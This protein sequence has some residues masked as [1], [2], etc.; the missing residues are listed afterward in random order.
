MKKSHIGQLV[1]I[2]VFI[3]LVFSLF[4][5]NFGSMLQ[6]SA[7]SS[8]INPDLL[9]QVSLNKT[10]TTGKYDDSSSALSYAGTWVI[11]ASSKAIQGHLH[12]SQKANDNVTF[13]IAGTAFALIYTSD[14]SHGIFDVFVDGSK[15]TT[16][17]EYTSKIIYQHEWDSPHVNP[18]THTIKLVHASGE[19]V[20]VDQIK[21]SGPTSAQPTATTNSNPT[22]TQ[23]S[24][25]PTAINPTTTLSSTAAPSPTTGNP[26]AVNTS[27][28]PPS[29]TEGAPAPTDTSTPAPSQLSA[30]SASSSST[31]SPKPTATRTLASPLPNTYEFDFG[32]GSSP[33]ASGYTRVTETTAYTS[34]GFGWT[35]TSGLQSRDRTTLADD[36]KRDFVM[37]DANAGTF[38]VD[39]P[40][41]NYSV[42]ITMGDQDYAHD[43]MVVKANGTTV[44]G[45]VDTALG[46]FV[47]N[48]F[49]VS[50]SGGS[51]TL[52]F[53]DAGGSDSAWIVNALTIN[54]GAVPP[55]PTATHAAP[56]ATRSSTPLPSPT[57]TLPI[58]T[59]TRS[60]TPIPSP[61]LGIST[62]T[63][64]STPNTYEFDFGTGSS[65]LASGYTRV[66]ETTAY[67]S[68]GFGWT[69]TSGLQSR[70]RTTL[71]DD[72]KRDFVMSDANAGT[73]KVD[74][75]NDNYS[76]TI[77]M[78]DQDYAHDDMVVKANGTT[79]L[80]DVDTALG[81]FV[82]NTFAVS[83]SGG[84]LTLVFSD[85]GGSDSA[86]I[87]NA[88]TI[89]PGSDPATSTSTS[90]APTATQ[91]STPL[92]SP[93][94][95]LPIPTATGS[96]IPSSSP[97]PVVSL[98]P[99]ISPTPTIATNYYVDIIQGSDSNPGSQSQPWKTLQKAVNTVSSG[100]TINIQPG[101]YAQVNISKSM[102]ILC[103]NSVITGVIITADNV[104]VKNCAAAN[105]SDHGYVISGNNNV[106]NGGSVHDN[107][108]GGI[109]VSG[110]VANPNIAKN[111]L[112]ENVTITHNGQNCID[113]RG[114]NSIIRDNDCSN[115][116]QYWPGLSSYPTWVDADCFRFFN[117]GGLWQ[118]N[119]CHDINFDAV[120]NINPHIDC[121]QT[122][123]DS[124]T[125]IA[126]HD[127]L[128][129]G[130]LCNFSMEEQ[131][132]GAT[133][134]WQIEEGAY[135]LKMQNNIVHVV[136]LAQ[137]SSGSA[138]THDI[139]FL[140]NTFVGDPSYGDS[141]GIYL[142]GITNTTI[143]NNVFAYQQN[144]VGSIRP[145]AASNTTLSVGYNCVYIAGRNPWRAADPG[146]V[147]GLNPLFVNESTLDYHL[148]SASPCINKGMNSGVS[149]DFDGKTRPQG[150]GY[151]MGAYEY[152][153]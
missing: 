14:P 25:S 3:G 78:G 10:M 39:L 58:P 12:E 115:S 107:A 37:S 86:W 133:K 52:V 28:P 103:T 61:T 36:L 125:Y 89:N 17:S 114:L 93:T 150:S 18:G 16:I 112:I 49:A 117:S 50:V 95:T 81:G 94:P 130:N 41:G 138:T 96:S 57:S 71:A 90:G 4:G 32:T 40:N 83:V 80:G 46:G 1:R 38:K 15:L 85:A 6:V 31:P 87:A 136:I 23:R 92:P 5:N 73:F 144:G 126:G 43:D 66:T 139:S 98:T 104:T 106:I 88:L 141:Q 74:L 113:D 152:V 56:T 62:A 26:T 33:L 149:H 51:L 82:V 120:Y 42:T 34:G 147:W 64:T 22:A 19:Y 11:V 70:D 109:L 29:Q 118:G 59:A 142:T 151:D 65:P 123:S 140:N 99:S 60:S 21:V 69:S 8:S 53:S 153:P 128:F 84:S 91:T 146:D 119:K 116:I 143:K 35:S 145:D 132:G 131:G 54:P 55:T 137:I 101:T 121:F 110:T 129:D 9:P 127:I 63:R 122:F 68:G 67:T 77:T 44:L 76:V 2:V 79:V 30:D 20:G 111:T 45:D 102:T 47:V 75:P 7:G 72:L 100:A 97:T 27:T 13:T 105:S 135:N 124:S 108:W 148:Q 24:V 48:T 134:G